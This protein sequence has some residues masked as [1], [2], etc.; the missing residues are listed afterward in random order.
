MVIVQDKSIECICKAII[1]VVVG[2]HD[3][4][5]TKFSANNMLSRLFLPMI[6]I[7]HFDKK[8]LTIV[9]KNI[10]RKIY[11]SQERTNLYQQ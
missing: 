2:G 5:G 6:Y 8:Q 7:K 4:R 3:N 1:P 11:F 9:I 10:Q